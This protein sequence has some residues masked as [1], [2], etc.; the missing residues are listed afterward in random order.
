MTKIVVLGSSYVIPDEAHENTHLAL[1]GQSGIVMIDCPGRVL[2]RLR[3]AGLDADQV[4][5]VILTHFHPDHVDGV[6]MLIMELWL[7]GRKKPLRFYGLQHCLARIENLMKAYDWDSWPGLFPILFHP[8][9]EQERAPVLENADF[10]IV[11]SPVQ[12]FVP[13][14]GLRVTDKRTG[15]SLAYS[16]D[17]QP[18]PAA[19]NLANGVDLLFHEAAGAGFGHSSAMQAG[20]V[21]REAWAKRLVL[22]HYPTGGQDTSRLAS[23]A[24]TAFG[25]PVLLA[26][27]LMALEL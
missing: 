7:K 19:H 12:H 6:P 14:I 9:E 20:L 23:E 15:R 17:T 18:C 5:D 2:L 21:A 10:Y 16:C 27:D 13:T 26:E 22:I 1:L 3:R 4:G 25:G 24:E 11:A 8:V